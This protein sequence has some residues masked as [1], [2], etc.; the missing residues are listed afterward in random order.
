M[1]AVR[2][3]HHLHPA[4]GKGWCQW[5]GLLPDQRLHSSAQTSERNPTTTTSS[6]SDYFRCSHLEAGWQ[7]GEVFS[8]PFSLDGRVSA[9][10]ACRCVLRSPPARPG[11]AVSHKGRALLALTTGNFMYKKGP[12]K[13]NG[14]VGRKCTKPRSFLLPL[15]T[16]AE[17]AASPSLCCPQEGPGFG[18]WW[19]SCAVHSPR[20]VLVLWTCLCFGWRE[21]FPASEVF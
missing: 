10:Q 8:S 1:S 5:G 11:S 3:P 4:L 6:T 21:G 20:Q 9:L 12:C 7:W 16:W 15:P 18:C 14:K 17:E 13:E 19:Q 2:L